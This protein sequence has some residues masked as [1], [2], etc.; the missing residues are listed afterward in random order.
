[1][2]V[3]IHQLLIHLSLMNIIDNFSL[4]I[5][6]FATG[7]FLPT[8]TILDNLEWQEQ[9]ILMGAMIFGALPFTFHYSFVRKKFLSPKL[10]IEVL[11]YFMILGSAILLLIWL[12][13]LDPLT[14]AFY[15]ISAST[16]S[17]L[18]SQ[19][20]V[21]FNGA[22]HAILILLMIIGGCGFS[23]AGGIKVFRF[24]QVKECKKLFSKI[25][26]SEL[27]PQREKELL[28][29]VL[30]IM[31]FLGTISITAIYLTTI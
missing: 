31:L 25:S 23:T 14:S 24:L 22:S 2:L 4:A 29:T 13:G 10:G 1:M 7:G 3:K 30:I 15:S 8:S 16:T 27:T 19:N 20:I 5:S 18:H 9:V 6:G 12:S 17:G 26:R 11:A 28:S 21:N